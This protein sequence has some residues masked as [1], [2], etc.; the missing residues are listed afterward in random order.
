[1]HHVMQ[2]VMK[3]DHKMQQRQQDRIMSDKL[4]VRVCTWFCCIRSV[5]HQAWHPIHH[6]SPRRE[7]SQLFLLYCFRNTI[8]QFFCVFNSAAPD[9]KL[10]FV[11]FPENAGAADKAVADVGKRCRIH[12]NGK[13]CRRDTMLVSCFPSS[14]IWVLLISKIFF[15]CFY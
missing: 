9:I 6:L 15:F 12:E 1:M 5:T 8:R 7:I 2:V 11:L 3:R 10:I 13:N 14:H 4:N